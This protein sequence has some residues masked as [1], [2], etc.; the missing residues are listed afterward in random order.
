MILYKIVSSKDNPVIF[1]F[2]FCLIFSFFFISS[3]FGQG[4]APKVDYATGTNPQRVFAAD[5]DGDNDLDLA[6]GNDGSATVSVFKNNGNGTFAAKV[7]YPTGDI[8]ISVFAAD[9]DGD[10]DLDLA[11]ANNA[12]TTVS[13]LKNNGDG[14]FA[15]KVDYETGAGPSSVFAADLDGDTDLDLAVTNHGPVSVSVLKN[16]GDG[17]FAAKVDY[18]TGTNPYS[19]FAADLDGD[20]DLDLALV[21]NGSNTVSVFKNNGDGTFAAKVDYPTGNFPSSVFAADLDGDTDRDLAVTNAGSATVSVF[22]N[23]GAGTFAAKVDYATG[24][25]PYFVFAADLDGDNDLDLAVANN[26]SNTVSRLKN[27]GNGTFAAKV[28]YG[29]GAFPRSVFAAD[30]DGDTDNDLAVANYGSNTV[31]VLKNLTPTPVIVSITDVGNDQ[32]KQVRIRW[33]TTVPGDTFATKYDIFRRIDG[34]TSLTINGALTL[35]SPLPADWEQVA[36]FS[37]YGDTLYNGIAPTLVDSTV[38]GGLKWSVFFVRAATNS[39]PLF[40]DSQIDSGYS[41]DNLVPSPPSNLQAT[42][43]ATIASLHWS[44]VSDEDFDYYYVYRDTIS[45]FTLSPTKRVKAT[46]DTSASDTLSNP[47][48]AYFYL[49]TAVDFSGNE[50][51]PSNQDQLCTD[52]AGDAN[53]SGGAPNL[54]DIISLVNHVFKGALKPSPA[55]RGDANAS[56][57][58]NLSDIIYEVNFVFKGGPAPIK[59]GVCCL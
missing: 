20:N 14:T 31:S 28:D 36:T 13:V 54:T 21:N 53:G 16:N 8:P 59:S 41:V 29:T 35:N 25:S 32:G 7:D 3:S 5:L 37:A 19:P 42:G 34:S 33:R 45:G 18:A 23:N 9:L 57:A 38:S 27:N 55:C 43:T 22:K 11:V 51:Q 44:P 24:G 49:V 58:I 4:F 2:L 30:L 50:G 26:T 46:S 39:P 56:G 47:N 6:V 48:K 12:D 52:R 10:N 1:C 40:W 15:A 17:T